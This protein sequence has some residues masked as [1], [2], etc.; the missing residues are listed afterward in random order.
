[1]EGGSS[2]GCWVHDQRFESVKELKVGV[3]FCIVPWN[4]NGVSLQTL[5]TPNPHRIPQPPWYL[6]VMF[7][8]ALG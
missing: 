3:L 8:R 2:I 4:Y 5:P 6:S 1:M 7:F